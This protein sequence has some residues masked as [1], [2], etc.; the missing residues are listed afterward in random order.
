MS[1]SIS[2]VNQALVGMRSGGWTHL[3]VRHGATEPL[4]IERLMGRH[5]HRI[6]YRHI[7]M[8]AGAEAGAFARYVY[9]DDLFPTVTFRRAYD[10]LSAA[11]PGTRGDLEY[12]RVLLLAASTMESEVDA[13][14]GLLLEQGVL[15]TVDRVKALVSPEQTS[16]PELPRLT[17]N[18]DD[19]DA[20]LVG[21]EEAAS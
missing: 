15:P 1:T 14:L 12:L 10:A 3:E 9:R 18:L 20:L 16:V 21:R 4:T 2:C 7:I 11:H 5:R 19:Y 8:V 17:V 13:A 6:D